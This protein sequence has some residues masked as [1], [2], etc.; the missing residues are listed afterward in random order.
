MPNPPLSKAYVPG[1]RNDVFISYCHDDN[2]SISEDRRGWVS[3]FGDRL[4]VRL[5]QLL[6]HPVEVWRDEKKLGGDHALDDEIQSQ[7]ESCAVFLAVVTP[8][9]LNSRYCTDE[10]EWFLDKV[11]D[12]L[13]VGSR[14]RGIRVVKTPQSDRSHR[15]VFSEGLGFEFFRAVEDDVDE[16]APASREFDDRFGK[17]CKSIKGLL[18]TLR[19]D[20]VSVY[21]AHCPSDLQSEREKLVTEFNDQGYRILPEIQIDSRNVDKVAKDGLEAARLSVHLLGAENDSLAVRQARIAM[22]LE[23]PLIAWSS[24]P[25]LYLQET[26]YGEFL[27]ELMEYQDP[28]RQSQYLDRTRL[29]RVKTEVLELLQ[30]RPAPAVVTTCDGRRVYILCDREDYKI[31]WQIRNRIVD[32]D[33][34]AVDLP[35]TAPLDPADLRADHKRKLQSCDGL[36]L[37]WGQASTSWFET[38]KS[39][40]RARRFSS[41]AIGVGA[42]EK[43]SVASSDAPVIPLY[44]DFQYKALDPFLT[45]LRQ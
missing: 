39:D 26:E 44:G 7:I 1:F 10:R 16:F 21:V 31:A 24:K 43:I 33:G 14:M 29:E 38:T 17:V 25:E 6:G 45:P 41:G 32:Q 19:R 13:R 28:L 9:Y 8:L 4:K 34:F 2:I 40:L 3:D 37:Y 30:P 20:R 36:L 18:E 22:E 42:E 23:K 5:K 15:G 12:K 35:E 11:G 27:R